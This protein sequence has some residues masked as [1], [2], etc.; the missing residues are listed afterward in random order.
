MRTLYLLLITGILSGCNTSPPEK[1]VKINKMVIPVVQAQ[2]ESKSSSDSASLSLYQENKQQIENVVSSLKNEYL[3]EVKPREMFDVHS[4][5]YQV[6]ASLT[7]LEQM[8][9]MNNFYYKEHNQTGL[10]SIN[11]SVNSLIE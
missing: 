3:H 9:Q 10:L 5:A 2:P 11:Q 6:Y 4:Q 7:K 1:V 8:Q